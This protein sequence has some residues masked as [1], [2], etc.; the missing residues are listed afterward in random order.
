MS[1][2][3]RFFQGPR[4]DIGV[5]S[6]LLFVMMAG[7]ALLETARDT[8]FLTTLPGSQLPWV[9]FAVAMVSII[10]IALQN[11]ARG[12][13]RKKSALTSTLLLV[14]AVNL[15]FFF[16]PQQG[17]FFYV[18]YV[19]VAV[20][21]TVCVGQFW[22]LM[23][24]RFLL[25][26][27][28]RVYTVIGG[29]GLVGATLGA[30]LSGVVVKTMG[31]TSL[32]VFGTGFLALAAVVSQ[33]LTAQETVVSPVMAEERGAFTEAL[34]DTYGRKLILLAFVFTLTLT[35]LDIAFRSSIATHVEKSQIGLFFAGLNTAFNLLALGVQ[36][37]AAGR[38]VQRL[39]TM[40]S[41]TI[42]PSL[43]FASLTLFAA[44]VSFPILILA[45]SIDGALRHSLNRTA[46]ELLFIP[47]RGTLR[48][49]VKTL[50][51]SLGTRFGQGVAA[52]IA[53]GLF[54]LGAF[55]A[56]AAWVLVTT[57]GLWLST[58]WMLRKDYLELFRSQLRDEVVPTSAE[59]R[60]LDQAS[61]ET[62][63]S[64]LNSEDAERVIHAMEL[65]AA[66]GKDRLIPSSMLYHPTPAIVLS[67][68]RT[69]SQTKRT[70]YWAAAKNLI[71]S[72]VP[73]VQ[74]LAIAVYT[75]TAPVIDFDMLR[76][77]TG[78]ADIGV[79]SSAFVAL[80]K[81]NEVT[82]KELPR[83]S[84][85]LTSGSPEQ[86]AAIL[87]A[88]REQNVADFDEALPEITADGGPLLG[89]ELAKLVQA[90]P[91]PRFV[92]LLLPFL[93]LRGC[94]AETRSAFL[95]IGE[96]AYL[97]LCEALAKEEI[98]SQIRRHIPRTLSRFRHPTLAR[99][100]SAQLAVEKDRVVFFKL[101]RGLGRMV[102][103]DPSLKIDSKTLMHSID[104][105]VARWKE[106]AV[107]RR[108]LFLQEEKVRT[109]PILIQLLGV[110]EGGERRAFEELFRLL[111]MKFPLE[112]FRQIQRS[113]QSS[114]APSRESGRELLEN[115]LKEPRRAEILSLLV[116]STARATRTVTTL[117]LVLNQMRESSHPAISSLA[118]EYFGQ[119]GEAA[120]AV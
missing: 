112:D 81:N 108:E 33:F 45:K 117:D 26:Q 22:L 17:P 10:V 28:K 119:R 15:V 101:L 92:P 86:R 104:R 87:R 56:T 78:S 9:Y 11:R 91:E 93:A 96:P 106:L 83:A 102:T 32:L 69:L 82:R 90:R 57:A 50:S 88:I 79:R 21:A 51:D 18:F 76:L 39:G 55:P 42:F 36:W 43:L 72:A 41:L 35:M 31:P 59:L 3:R 19:W 29:G 63:V 116:G 99:V 5:G 71:G 23:A 100:L 1:L 98:P 54:A 27:A 75:R 70:D 65:L 38:I 110:V 85:W 6:L 80:L 34:R 49:H 89:I 16:A 94:R 53:L 84:Q 62:L 95:L 4:K 73:E 114:D 105:Q 14:S 103:Q 115:L 64:T 118:S 113:L 111:G 66:R 40:K 97:F 67:A 74:C 109:S 77:A 30:L 44:T 52:L 61:I 60:D 7:H 24:D 8:L 120:H 37:F 2:I 12:W 48:A 25:S 47:I 58:V 107:W 46:F 13:L 20:I 68:L